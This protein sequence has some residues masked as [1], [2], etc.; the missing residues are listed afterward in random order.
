M[1]V[2]T[3]PSGHACQPPGGF[4]SP[5][6]LQDCKRAV[7]ANE[8][9]Y[10]NL[11]NCAWVDMEKSRAELRPARLVHRIGEMLESAELAQTEPKPIENIMN[12]K[13]VRVGGLLFAYTL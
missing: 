5:T 8:V 3:T 7:L 9:K 1:R 10:D 4:H 13:Q 6:D 2:S 11:A 12:G